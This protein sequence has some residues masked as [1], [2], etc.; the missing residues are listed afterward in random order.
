MY[1]N[2]SINPDESNVFIMINL[3]KRKLLKY[4]FLK[5]F[6]SFNKYT[7]QAFK[8]STDE[9][10]KKLCWRCV[11]EIAKNN[12]KDIKSVSLEDIYR[13]LYKIRKRTPKLLRRI[14]LNQIMKFKDISSKT[15]D[16]FNLVTAIGYATPVPLMYVGLKK[17]VGNR[18][19]YA[20]KMY[21]I[22]LIAE[23]IYKKD[24]S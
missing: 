18:V 10:F 23:E 12:D 11:S 22:S 7:A 19:E 2:K 24:T 16:T 8:V 20:F 13:V 4:K 9:E 1:L 17:I 3:I 5:R 6:V 14:T 21:I 15:G